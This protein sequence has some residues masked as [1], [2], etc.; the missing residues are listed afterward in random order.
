MTRVRCRAH[1]INRARPKLSSYIF[2]TVFLFNLNAPRDL[3]L[4]LPVTHFTRLTSLAIYFE[5][6]RF[7]V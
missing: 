4:H 7:R 6:L 3:Y 1:V 5:A 2:P